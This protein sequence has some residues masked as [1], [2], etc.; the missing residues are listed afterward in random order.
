MLGKTEGTIKNVHI[1][2]LC[3][4]YLIFPV[5]LDCTFLIVPSVF[6]YVYLSPVLY[7]PHV[8]SLWIVNS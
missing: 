1:L 5:S 2:V 6:F 7:V 8:A 3:Y 4:L